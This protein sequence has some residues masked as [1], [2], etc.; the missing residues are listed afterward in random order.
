MQAVDNNQL[1]IIFGLII[2]YIF[3]IYCQYILMSWV[4]NSL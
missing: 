4:F 3:S 2:D 1:L